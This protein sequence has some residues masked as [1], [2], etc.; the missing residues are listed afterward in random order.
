MHL[1]MQRSKWLGVILRE[2]RQNAADCFGIV[3]NFGTNP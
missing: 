3:I 2:I 1:Q